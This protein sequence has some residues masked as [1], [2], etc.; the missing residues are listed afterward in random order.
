MYTSN[1]WIVR[2]SAL[3]S[4]PSFFYDIEVIFF[5]ISLLILHITLGLQTT[6]NDYLHNKR[7]KILLVVLTR[8]ASLELLRYV[9]ELLI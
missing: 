2:I 8:L 3:L 7:V 6:L 9:L 5:I 4:F 1:W